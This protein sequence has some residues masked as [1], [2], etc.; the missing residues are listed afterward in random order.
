MGNFEELP[1]WYD[2]PPLAVQSCLANPFSK[3]SSN[4]PWTFRIRTRMCEHGMSVMIEIP[5]TFLLEIFAMRIAAT[6][7]VHAV[8]WDCVGW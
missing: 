5:A 8:H 1:L 6:V 2:I 4:E 3:I 7:D